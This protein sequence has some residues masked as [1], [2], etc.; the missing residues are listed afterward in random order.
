MKNRWLLA[1]LAAGAIAA[2]C[3]KK[4]AAEAEAPAPVQVTGV[5]Q[6]PIRRIVAGDG[7][8][9]PNAQSSVMPNINKTVAKFYVNR[10]DH[11]KEGQIIAT[12][13]SRDL[14]AAVDNAKAQ[15]NQATLN[16]HSVELATVPESVVKAQAD[17]ESDKETL[18]AA[19]KLLDSQQKLFE[20]GAL[21]GR[22]VD[23]AR[24]AYATAKSALAGATEHLRALNSVGKG[25]QIA[26][27][28]AQLQSSKAQLAAAEAQFSYS[29]IRSPRSG[30]V[31]DRPLY[32]GEMAV[33]GT[34]MLTVMDISKVVA[35]VNIPQNQV[36]SVKVG[37][38]A[39]VIPADGGDAAQGRV[40]VVS[41]A[42][43]PASTTAQVW[44]ECDN[45]G[46]K[47]KPGTSVHVKIVTELV[48]NAT[49]VLATAIL[50]GEEG[51]S[52]VLVIDADS[53]AHRHVVQIGIREGDKVQ[54]LNGARPGDE[55]V[56][57]GG[58]GVDD[59]QKVKKVDTTVQESDDDNAP[60]APAKDSKKDEAKPKAK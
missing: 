34:P 3:A 39:D 19:R 47:L 33:P 41:P 18:D 23:E 36:G 13:E 26:T 2:G 58:L 51:G 45:S 60:D 50:P 42:T 31:S 57:V 54:L 40:K 56:V 59:K 20:Q 11:V 7:V 1:V 52:A 25:D 30:I 29:E 28:Q 9:F 49:T 12:L 22:R 44:V 35:R 5:T 6:E 8:L 32:E 24:V 16:V 27:A 37:Q 4:E 53:V 17:V 14:K 43:D 46:E 21:A 15:V 48:K 38:S 10:G 55:V